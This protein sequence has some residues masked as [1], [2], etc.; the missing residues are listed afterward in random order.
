MSDYTNIPNP[1]DDD[2]DATRM[3]IAES[4]KNM[5]FGELEAIAAGSRD[6][7]HHLR[8]QAA[9]RVVEYHDLEVSDRLTAAAKHVG[10]SIALEVDVT[11]RDIEDE[12]SRPV[13]VEAIIGAYHRLAVATDGVTEAEGTRIVSTITDGG[14]VGG[15]RLDRIA[16]VTPDVIERAFLTLAGTYELLRRATADVVERFAAVRIA[17]TNAGVMPGEVFEANDDTTGGAA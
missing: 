2:P 6:H 10:E 11:D 5:S 14:A 16:E 12:V 1:S 3:R 13:T 4:M 15:I 9:D 8:M 17:A 7:L